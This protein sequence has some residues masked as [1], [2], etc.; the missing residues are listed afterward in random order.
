MRAGVAGTARRARRE[1]AAYEEVD[2]ELEPTV[3]VGE[4]ELVG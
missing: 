1:R 2:E 3:G 4:G